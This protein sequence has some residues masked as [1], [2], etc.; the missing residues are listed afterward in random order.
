MTYTCSDVTEMLLDNGAQEDDFIGLVD[1]ESNT[2]CKR[3]I[4]IWVVSTVE[5]VSKSSCV[6]IS[7][8]R[9][10][11]TIMKMIISA[12][13]IEVP[14]AQGTMLALQFSLHSHHISS[15]VHVLYKVNS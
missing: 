13:R 7:F 2:I 9:V 8:L 5:L 6:S 4:S 10:S 12:G 11:L 3:F 1:L 14:M 15:I